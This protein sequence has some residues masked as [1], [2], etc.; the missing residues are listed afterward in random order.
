MIDF[1]ETL[2]K[3]LPK[4]A[5]FNDPHRIPD[6]FSSAPSPFQSHWNGGKLSRHKLNFTELFN[7]HTLK[8]WI[9][10]AHSG[11]K[12]SF[13]PLCAIGN[14]K[15]H[16]FCACQHLSGQRHRPLLLTEG[17]SAATPVTLSLLLLS[18]PREYS[19]SIPE[20]PGSFQELWTHSK[21]LMFCGM[22]NNFQKATGE[23]KKKK[24]VTENSTKSLHII[25]CSL[26]SI[27]H[28]TVPEC[29]SEMWTSN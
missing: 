29:P 22:K 14:T 12:G 23:K 7:E 17:K 27:H 1:S 28:T 15:I 9:P 2:E 6:T 21:S 18:N 10:K 11:W 19:L 26:F 8:K 5:D 25:P 24:K 16:Q 13:F 4:I 3:H 20:T